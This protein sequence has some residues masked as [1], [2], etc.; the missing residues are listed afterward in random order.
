MVNNFF[1][2]RRSKFLS[3]QRTLFDLPPV[4]FFDAKLI[5]AL[6]FERE[7]RE[8]F[9]DRVR[10]LFPYT[11]IIHP[12]GVELEDGHR[13]SL[14]D[15]IS[16]KR[17]S[18][19][20]YYLKYAGTDVNINWGSRAVYYAASMSKKA[21]G[22]LLDRIV[23]DY[24]ANRFWILQK[25]YRMKYQT[26]YYSR[27]GQTRDM[28]GYAKFSGF[29]GPGGLMGAMNMTRR[30]HKVHGGDETVVSIVV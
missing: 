13:L 11:C 18:G 1:E 22:D 25:G 2:S 10:E 8:Y 30:H 19:M 21:L 6:P 5:M 17:S 27:G 12:E 20:D 23:K 26:R 29:Y 14:E 3:G 15:F 4:M 16:L 7:S 24:R 9:S 28:D